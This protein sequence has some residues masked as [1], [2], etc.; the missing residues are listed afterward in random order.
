M[1]FFS[2]CLFLKIGISSQRLEW[3]PIEKDK[4]YYFVK[5]SLIIGE[6]I[7]YLFAFGILFAF[8]YSLLWY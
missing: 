2:W 7:I 1:L 8:V 4:N 5:V 6:L 3:K